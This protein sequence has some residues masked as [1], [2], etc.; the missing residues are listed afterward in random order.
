MKNARRNNAQA[1]A[2]ATLPPLPSRDIIRT[3][4]DQHQASSEASVNNPSNQTRMQKSSSSMGSASTD[5]MGGVN[6]RS[7][8]FQALNLD[9]DVLS[10]F[11]ERKVIA[12]Q[13]TDKDRGGGGASD[14]RAADSTTSASHK[15]ATSNLQANARRIIIPLRSSDRNRGMTAAVLNSAKLFTPEASNDPELSAMAKLLKTEY[16]ARYC[17]NIGVTPT[18]A[19]MAAILKKIPLESCSI[20]LVYNSAMGRNNVVIDPSSTEDRAAISNGQHQHSPTRSS[21][22]EYDITDVL[23]VPPSDVGVSTTTTNQQLAPSQLNTRDPHTEGY[24]PPFEQYKQRFVYPFCLQGKYDVRSTEHIEYLD[25][26]L[27]LSAHPSTWEFNRREA[28]DRNIKNE[29]A[30][31]VTPVST[32]H[33][34]EFQQRFASSFPWDRLQDRVH[35]H[36]IAGIQRKLQSSSL[37][38]TIHSIIRLLFHVYVQPYAAG[39]KILAAATSTTSGDIG[40][41]SMSASNDMLGSASS[42]I[43]D[44]SLAPSNLSPLTQ[45]QQES[46]FLDIAESLTLSGTGPSNTNFARSKDML[47]QALR[48]ICIRTVVDTAFVTRFPFFAIESSI[49]L[50]IRSSV[51][52][53]ILGLADPTGL[54]SRIGVFESAPQTLRQTRTSKRLPASTTSLASGGGGGTATGSS[55]PRSPL[56]QL[57][58]RT[59]SQST[60]LEGKSG[61]SDIARG[62]GSTAQQMVELQRFVTPNTRPRLIEI[63]RQT[64]M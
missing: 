13:S 11:K 36:V 62:G 50:G 47:E 3:L 44:P 38:T 14:T 40:P 57:L 30:S 56:M 29:L 48:I 22:R 49:G 63:V 54:V 21:R 18:Q 15:M 24:F 23:A 46:L 37:A 25:R 5:D 33:V 1:T 12:G 42:T 55:L 2:T 59:T 41:A 60:L 10:Y 28:T 53:L 8:V 35:P 58:F 7:C 34:L 19:N 64:Q 52:A 27:V 61:A 39:C 17:E 31:L 26:L 45:S 20:S 43:K 9:T 4:R 51:D 16:A 6:Q 32:T